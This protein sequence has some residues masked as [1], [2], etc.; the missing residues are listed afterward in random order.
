MNYIIIGADQK[1]YGPVSSAELSDWIAQRRAN[2]STK[3][4]EENATEWKK[5]SEVPEFAEALARGAFALSEAAAKETGHFSKNHFEILLMQHPP[6]ILIGSCLR[7]AWTLVKKHLG[8]VV[9][10][11]F[12][13]MVTMFGLGLISNIP[14]LGGLIQ[15]VLQGPLMG[16]FYGF[17]L[18]LIRADEAEVKDL[19]AGFGPSCTPLMLTS[20]VSSLIAFAS[21][22]AVGLPMMW[23]SLGGALKNLNHPE[24]LRLDTF[25]P[26]AIAGAVLMMVVIMALTFLWI[27]SL[28]LVIDKGLAFWDAM[29]ISRKTVMKTWPSLL[30]L[31]IVSGFLSGLGILACCVG[32]LFTAPIAPAALMY[33]YK[34]I[35]EG[36]VSRS[37]G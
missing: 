18:K 20:I 11:T 34:D 32:V 10:S 4:R 13:F 35:Y 2:G 6:R 17:Y 33:A 37:E 9:G 3:I 23:T 24:Q 22:I 28:P 16:G 14:I 8:L 26:V 7:R 30:G 31:I 15:L 1:E 36:R 21:A 29:E 27:F 12:V 25:G 5:L 19:F